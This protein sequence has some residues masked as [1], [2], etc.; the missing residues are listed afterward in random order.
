MP[1]RHN[2]AKN[3]EFGWTHQSPAIVYSESW[4]FRMTTWVLTTIQGRALALIAQKFPPKQS[5]GLEL[6]GG[7]IS[8]CPQGS[9]PDVQFY[10]FIFEAFLLYW[11]CASKGPFLPSLNSSGMVSSSSFLLQ[12]SLLLR[13]D[14]YISSVEYPRRSFLYNSLVQMPTV[15]AIFCAT[16]LEDTSFPFVL[17]K[18][19][20]LAISHHPKF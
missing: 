10:Q 13:P 7:S 9:Q 12:N 17:Q 4:C 16:C 1:K 8:C 14:F 11:V 20:F 6:P 19:Y 2:I 18:D 15:S 3:L 5:E